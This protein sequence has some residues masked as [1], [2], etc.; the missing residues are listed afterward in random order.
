MSRKNNPQI[1][2]L[3]KYILFQCIMFYEPYGDEGSHGKVAQKLPLLSE[4]LRAAI[5]GNAVLRC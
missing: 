1:T 2:G 4:A 3:R 5:E